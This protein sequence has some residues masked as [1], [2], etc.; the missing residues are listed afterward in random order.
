M[1]ASRIYSKL[2]KNVIYA[3]KLANFFFHTFII[4]PIEH[5]LKV[6][7]NNTQGVLVEGMTNLN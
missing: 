7:K 5:I 4:K 2:K 1:L 6:G 3:G